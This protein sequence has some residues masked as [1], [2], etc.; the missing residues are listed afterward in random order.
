MKRSTSDP[1]FHTGTS[2]RFKLDPTTKMEYKPSSSTNS[3]TTTKTNNVNVS[4]FAPRDN[5]S[6]ARYFPGGINN[7]NSSFISRN[8]FPSNISGSG[9]SVYAP[10]TS[11]ETSRYL[12]TPRITHTMKSRTIVPQEDRPTDPSKLQK[13]RTSA[14]SPL[15]NMFSTIP[16]DDADE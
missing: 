7:T 11:K 4:S 1:S 3:S 15:S 5:E 8:T 16:M 14:T 9:S 13:L 10:P 6:S 2:A 12:I